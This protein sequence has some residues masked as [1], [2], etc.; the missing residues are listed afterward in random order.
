MINQTQQVENKQRVIIFLGILLFLIAVLISLLAVWR[1][2]R[3]RLFASKEQ[4]V[5]VQGTQSTEESGDEGTQPETTSLAVVP[6]RDD[7]LLPD[8]SIVPPKELYIAGSASN[9]LLRFSTTF[10]NL[11]PGPL[12]IFGHQDYE[13]ELT[14]A[15]Q[16]IYAK[17]APGVYQD[18]GSFEL[19]PTHNHWH[20]DNHVQYQLWSI[21]EDGSK[22]EMLSDTG[23]FSFCIWDEHTYDL[24]IEG[25]PQTR[26]YTFVCNADRQGMSVG[27]G[28][29]YA[30]RVD[31]QEL[32]ITDIPDG[33]YILYYDVNPDRKIYETTFD[34]NTGQIRIR[35]T[36]FTVTEL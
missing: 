20:V 10:V 8:L 5:S 25:A 32:D 19:H 24:T 21:A 15:A 2:R 28:D 18:I 34:N 29:T 36:G 13:N 12:E 31:G 17:G 1:I 33:E 11:G 6:V 4:P 30:A 26:E 27:W 14:Y 22:K 23:K 9:K 16:Y 3:D 35:I 7:L